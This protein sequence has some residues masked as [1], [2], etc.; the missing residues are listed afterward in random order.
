MLRLCEEADFGG[1]GDELYNPWTHRRL[2]NPKQSMPKNGEH[3]LLSPN[4]ENLKNLVSKIVDDDEGASAAINQYSK[5][6]LRTDRGENYQ[7]NSELP[8]SSCN[9]NCITSSNRFNNNGQHHFESMYDKVDHRQMNGAQNHQRN[10]DINQFSQN[11]T[12]I[13]DKFASWSIQD[14]NGAINGHKKLVAVAAGGNGN[15][16]LIIGHNRYMDGNLRQSYN[17]LQIADNSRRVI[18]G[19]DGLITHPHQN[20]PHKQSFYNVGAAPFYPSGA[21]FQQRHRTKPYEI[22]QPQSTFI[23]SQPS[24]GIY[25]HQMV[26]NQIPAQPQYQLREAV[27]EQNHQVTQLRSIRARANIA[28]TIGSQHKLDYSIDRCYEHFKLLE[29]ERK[30]VLDFYFVSYDL[31]SLNRSMIIF[32]TID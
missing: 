17:R 5:D 14:S 8:F 32:V 9:K 24:R 23:P 22:Q 29:K 10:N 6:S 16:D 13:L 27:A 2:V 26:K 1:G 20:L 21:I 12:C 19:K 28:T 3:L 11:E 31:K 30:K 18:N 4:A 7:H 15:S 25:Q